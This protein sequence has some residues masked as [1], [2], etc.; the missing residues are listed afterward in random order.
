MVHALRV[1]GVLRAGN[2][3][4]DDAVMTAG[5]TTLGENA[6]GGPNLPR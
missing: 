6:G 4:V 5:G 2:A 1:Q 3:P